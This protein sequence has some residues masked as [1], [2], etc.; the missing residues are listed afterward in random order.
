MVGLASKG[1]EDPLVPV[2][3][4]LG[5]QVM[6]PCPAFDVNSGDQIQGPVLGKQALM[7]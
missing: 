6:S 1:A 7:D 3:L 4:V 2:S 5:L